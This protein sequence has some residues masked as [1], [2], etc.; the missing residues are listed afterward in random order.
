MLRILCLMILSWA[1]VMC[2]AQVG[3]YTFT[4]GPGE[5]PTAPNLTFT[6][7]SRT[8]LTSQTAAGAFNSSGFTSATSVDLNSYVEFSVMVNNGY[9][10]TLTSITLSSQKSAQGPGS[11]RIAYNAGGNFSNQFSPTF[12]PPASLAA[13]SWNFNDTTVSNGGVVIFRIYGWAAGSSSGTLRFDDVMLYGSVTPYTASCPSPTGV[14]VYAIT[15]NT[16][17]INWQRAPGAS[18]YGYALGYSAVAPATY[19]YT[20]DSFY[21]PVNLLKDT[22][23]YFYLKTYCS[24]DSSGIVTQ[25]FH[26]PDTV[27]TTREIKMMTYNLLNYPGSTA[28]VR[29]PKYRTT[30]SAYNPDILVVQEVSQPSGISSFLT[31]VLN[32]TNNTYSAGSFIDGPD[33][34][35]GIYYKTAKFQFISN[36]P[37]ATQ[38]RDISEFKLR[39]IESGDTII[40]Y[41]V[42]L[43]SSNTPA[44]EQARA[45][46][47]DSL[48]K[49][50]NALGPGKYFM[51][52][53]DFNIYGSSEQ[54]Y[55]NMTQNGTNVNGRFND[56]I[57]MSGTWQSSANAIHHTQSPRTTSFGGG[58]TGG[59]DDRFDMILF[60]DAIT[61]PGGIDIKPNSYAAYGNDGLHYNQA[62]NTPPFNVYPQAV[63]EAIH[64]G[65]DHIPVVV[66]LTYQSTLP[67]K[68]LHF[69]GTL[70]KGRAELKWA[71]AT[72][73]NSLHFEVQRSRNAG[74]WVA[75]GFVKAA[76][77]TSQ[78]RQY[79]FTDQEEIK[80]VVYYRLKQVDQNGR[81][82]YSDPIALYVNNNQELGATIHPNPVNDQ[83][84]LTYRLHTA[85]MVEV[86]ISN[87]SGAVV[88]QLN[89]EMKQEGAHQLNLPALSKGVYFLLLEAGNSKEVVKMV[90]N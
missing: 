48:R 38:L 28:S 39:V 9:S 57:T 73:T 50:T 33:S 7:F 34:D 88:L 49:C 5:V 10:L 20:T 77:T 27:T 83:S 42:H 32:F 26:T 60:S 58:A 40:I 31:N 41:S 70:K 11:A 36:T 23:C 66:T 17:K 52:C 65:S 80:G 54:C 64:D 56:I 74:E 55:L 46:E 89:K 62:L 30:V 85:A 37:I 90:V 8:A 24:N 78:R 22:T 59:M 79:T 16:C 81:S 75:A 15:P 45:A 2:R 12:T 84:V 35:N 43:K 51:V 68:L 19:T 72:E 14:N 67:V 1:F 87:A 86:S 25:S 21:Y 6:A 44:D 82:E 3:T 63:M 76:G 4:S 18:G 53:G 69:N 61:Q 47:T 29:E 71:T 13:T